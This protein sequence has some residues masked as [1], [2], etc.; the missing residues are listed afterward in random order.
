MTNRTSL[1]CGKRSG[2]HSTEPRT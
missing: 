1:S 2:L